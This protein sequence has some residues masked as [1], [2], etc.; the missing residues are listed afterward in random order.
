MESRFQFSIEN[1]HPYFFF[2]IIAKNSVKRLETSLPNCSDLR[3][4][5]YKGVKNGPFRN[6]FIFN[7]FW[8]KYFWRSIYQSIGNFTRITNIGT[9]VNVFGSISLKNAFLEG[10]FKGRVEFFLNYMHPSF[11]YYFVQNLIFYW[12]VYRHM[13]KHLVLKKKLSKKKH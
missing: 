1:Y 9:L 7:F 11:A 10:I 4:V 12:L 6:Y 13:L 8:K 5:L 3:L 2:L